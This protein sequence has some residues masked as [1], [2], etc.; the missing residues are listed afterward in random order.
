[1]IALNDVIAWTVTL[2]PAI[3]ALVSLSVTTPTRVVVGPGILFPPPDPVTLLE[4]PP[5]AAKASG[6]ANAN[7]ATTR[8]VIG[9]LLRLWRKLDGLLRLGDIIAPPR[10]NPDGVVQSPTP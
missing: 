8:H 3:G 6:V 10:S 7:A 5:L 2:A 4:F 9:Q 1:V